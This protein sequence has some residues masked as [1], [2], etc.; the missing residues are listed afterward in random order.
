MIYSIYETA[1]GLIKS[2]VEGMEFT[3]LAPEGHSLLVGRYS[4]G[5]YYVVDGE[6][7]ERAAMTPSISVSEIAADGV[8]ECVISGLP[9]PCRVQVNGAFYWLG[10]VAGGSLT[11]TSTEPGTLSV[12]VLNNPTHKPWKTTIHAT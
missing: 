11:I 8:D 6:A 9:D 10:E 2:V 4:P 1:T 7:V 12:T 3:V 5:E